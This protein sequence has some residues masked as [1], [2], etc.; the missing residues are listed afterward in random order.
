MAETIAVAD[1]PRPFFLCLLMGR[2]IPL[3]RH[4]CP[5]LSMVTAVLDARTLCFWPP[6]F[7][8]WEAAQG[9]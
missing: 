4:L 1:T 9:G 6:V 3:T 8:L 2:D 5:E 7:P